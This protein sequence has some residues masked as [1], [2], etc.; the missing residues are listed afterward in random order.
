MSIIIG[1]DPVEQSVQGILHKLE[2]GEP[3]GGR[4]ELERV[5][6]KEEAGR[7]GPDGAIQPGGTQN[8]A[9]ACK[10]AE[11]AACMANSD[12]GGALIVGVSNDGE[13]IGTSLEPEWLRQRIW[14]LTDRLLTVDV[15]EVVVR[16]VT[17]I[18]VR[19]PQALQ[20]IPFRKKLKWRVGAQCVE[21]DST[22]W[23]QRRMRVQQFDW[24][25]QP[26][27]MPVEE[28]T[29]AALETAREF[30]RASNEEHSQE[31]A[32]ARDIDLLKR[33]NVVAPDGTLTNAGAL[34][35]VGRGAPAVDF[36]RRAMVGE[37]SQ[38]RIRRSGRPLLQ[39]LADVFQALE[40]SVPTVHLPQGLIVGQAREIPL[41]AA[42][43]AI[44]N[45]VA[46]REWG[47]NEPTIVE[48]V[49]SQLKVTSP[50]GFV[51]GI[52]P[53][54][55]LTHPSRS[56]NA[57]L[58][59]LL[60]S[61]RIAEREGVGVDRMFRDMV[62]L[63]HESPEIE[64]I[65]GPYVRATLTGGAAD[66]AWIA[67]L[68]RLQGTRERAIDLNALLVLRQLLDQGWADEESVARVIQDSPATARNTIHMLVDGAEREVVPLVPVE[69]TIEQTGQAWRLS[70]KAEDLLHELDAEYGRVRRWPSRE[71]VAHSYA[72]HRGRIS[73]TEL[74]SLLRSA[75]SN[76]GSVLK[77]LEASGVLRPS[78]PSRRGKGFHYVHTKARRSL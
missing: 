34:A 78:W 67:W 71:S 32:E 51:A 70:H 53:S 35:F 13:V 6:L 49:G 45:G 16:S 64:E 50:G 68:R 42:R 11:A 39:E 52:T 57:A 56:R 25:L 46:H 59:E 43:E 61:L 8:E 9:A 14:Q 75:P 38:L 26:S 76:V 54:N 1:R 30:L 40:V 41:G 55:I 74:G 23:H 65:S 63:G 12:G 33:L 31:L 60:A 21:I 17:L 36:I 72:T 24:S 22:T 27:G 73:S 5:D 58:A 28:A 10:L 7:R 20:P 66:Q 4:D 3:V 29:P 19:A 47:V 37:D 62:R 2:I 48:Y 44:V 77:E 69:G 15:R 18:V